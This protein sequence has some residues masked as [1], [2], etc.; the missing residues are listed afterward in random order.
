MVNRIFR[1]PTVTLGEHI[2]PCPDIIGEITEFMKNDPESPDA[3]SADL[4][5]LY[6]ESSELNREVMNHV[7][8][9]LCG[10]S[11]PTLLR[12]ALA[13]DGLL[14]ALKIPTEIDTDELTDNT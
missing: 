14:K 12:S 5:Q 6:D 10:Y 9:R 11:F 8:V 7:L 1:G 13:D 2:Y 3:L 4:I